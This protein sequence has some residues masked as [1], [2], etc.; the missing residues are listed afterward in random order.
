MACCCPVFI[1]SA[2]CRVL[3]IL[4]FNMTDCMVNSQESIIYYFVGYIGVIL[5]VNMQ[6]EFTYCLHCFRL[7]FIRGYFCGI[8]SN[9]FAADNN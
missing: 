2:Q 9:T 4:L 3:H 8:V 6:R 5:F 7:D 1:Y